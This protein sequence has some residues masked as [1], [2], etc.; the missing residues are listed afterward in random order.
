MWEY[1]GRYQNGQESDWLTERETL[2]S[3]SPLQRDVFHALCDLYHP[4]IRVYPQSEGI[5]L[6]TRSEED[7]LDM[8][9]IG[10]EVRRTAEDGIGE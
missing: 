6:Q 9:P 8:Y 5:A 7:A 10:T 1:K 3:F 2:D 4:S